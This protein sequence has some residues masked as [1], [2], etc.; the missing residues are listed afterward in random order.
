MSKT[1]NIK[2]CPSVAKKL[3]EFQFLEEKA[4]SLTDEKLIIEYRNSINGSDW[5]FYLSEEICNRFEK[6]IKK[7]I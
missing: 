6:A 2:L 4:K 3:K 1:E 7:N 5:D